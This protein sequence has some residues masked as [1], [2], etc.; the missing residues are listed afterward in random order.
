MNTNYNLIN[1][2]YYSGVINL[3]PKFLRKRI[4]K[5]FRLYYIPTPL[6]SLPDSNYPILHSYVQQKK[7]LQNFKFTNKQKSFMTYEKL[8]ELLLLSFKKDEEF[9]FLDI[10]GQDVD[11]YLELK[12]EFKN[13]KYYIF[14]KREILDNFNKLKVEYSLNDFNI[15]FDESNLYNNN[16]EFI[17]FGSSIHY[18]KNY[19]EVLNNIIKISK[20]YILFSGTHFYK[21]NKTNLKKHL[22]AK[23]VNMLPFIFY[24]YFFNRDYFLNFFIDKGYSIN[25]EKKNLTDEVNYKN[26]YNL[27]DDIL[28]TDLLLSK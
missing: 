14:N 27:V 22:I 16:Y 2:I 12:K 26:F 6:N 17:N 4:K 10:G 9:S 24:C 23:Q 28:Y 3:L 13:V 8:I 21:S 1:L 5:K 20:K 7:Y 18:F 15:I 25:F 11:F 19:F